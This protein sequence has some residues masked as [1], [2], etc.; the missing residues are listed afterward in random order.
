MYKCNVLRVLDIVIIPG[1]S[2]TIIIPEITLFDKRMFTLEFCLT[3]AQIEK[4]RT[5]TGTEPVLI[6]N[7]VG[8]D[9]APLEDCAG[10][11]FYANEL[12]PGY[13]YRIRYG[14]N[15]PVDLIGTGGLAHYININSP[16]CKRQIDPGN[17]PATT[18]TGV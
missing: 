14:N 7:G 8:G 16:K 11:V 13:C 10:D 6:Q 4:L 3:R 17:A 5:A 2:V 12:I 15:G 9:I 1:T 18:T